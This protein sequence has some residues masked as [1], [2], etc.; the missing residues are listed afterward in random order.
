[1]SSADARPAGVAGRAGSAGGWTSARVAGSAP[2][3]ATACSTPFFEAPA[4]M[5]PATVALCRAAFATAESRWSER[6]SQPSGS[7]KA[8]TAKAV[9]A[10]VT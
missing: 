7:R 6:S 3:A 10:A 5:A 9:V 4:R 2:V 8:R 1:M